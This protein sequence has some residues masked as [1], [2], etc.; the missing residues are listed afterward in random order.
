M[1]TIRKLF[2]NNL[3]PC[4]SNSLSDE[5]TK[6]YIKEL[7][8]FLQNEINNNKKIYPKSCN[9]LNSLRLSPLKDIKIVI[10]GQDPYHG[11][12]QANGLAFS[13]N[14]EITIP[15]SLRNIYKELKNDLNIPTPDHGD[16]TN[17]ARQGVLLLN[18]V[19]TVEATRAGSH[20]KKGWETFTDKVVETINHNC[21]NIVFL[22][23]GNH[24]QKKCKDID[25]N[26]HKVLKS[27][28]PSP[29]S[30]SRGFFNN[31]HFSAANTYLKTNQKSPINW[32]LCI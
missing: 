25:M 14:K 9:I 6:P 23:W 29:L 13:V 28:H 30:A 2:S 21:N 19:L 31:N 16:L 15:P 32:N 26:K 4:W 10:I 3:P 7:T 11:E 5:L 17:W 27:V 1:K 20:Q 24:A 18:T 12:N 8:S 22:L